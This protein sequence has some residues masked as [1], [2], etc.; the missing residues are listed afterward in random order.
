LHWLP[1]SFS[2]HD[3]V[4]DVILNERGLS[5]PIYVCF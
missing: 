3:D 4:T 1:Q 2:K 5:V